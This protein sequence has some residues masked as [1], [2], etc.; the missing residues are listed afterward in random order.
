MF[1][2]EVE[3]VSF[4]RRIDIQQ[5]YSLIIFKHYFSRNFLGDDL[6][7]DALF[8]LFVQLSLEFGSE[9]HGSLKRDWAYYKN[10]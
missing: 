9:S 1:F 7:E 3:G 5:G 4:H 2:G 6:T 10:L 8:L